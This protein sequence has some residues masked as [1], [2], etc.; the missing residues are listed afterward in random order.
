M[1]RYI[2]LVKRR[3]DLD[4]E[5]FL[6]LWTQDHAALIGR[7]PGL[8]RYQFGPTFPAPGYEPQYDGIGQLWF[9]SVEAALAA[10]QS[11]AGQA[12]RADTPRFADTEAVRR[13]FAEDPASLGVLAEESRP[14]R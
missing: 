4:R 5:T 8:R 13:F 12:A 11:P 9:D 2:V 3:A 10:F 6:R 1:V 14:A 7:L